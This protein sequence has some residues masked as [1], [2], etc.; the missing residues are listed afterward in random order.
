MDALLEK[1][2]AID[3]KVWI[4]VGIGVSVVVILII[5]LVIGIKGNNNP[6]DMENETGSE[7][8]KGTEVYAGTEDV[9]GTEIFGTEMETEI[10]T[11]IETEMNQTDSKDSNSQPVV[12]TPSTEEGQ[13]ST[14]TKEDGEEI[15]GSG[16]LDEPYMEILD[17][18]TMALVTVE[19]P[20]GET[21]YYSIQRVGG[22]Y[23]SIEDKDAYVVESNGTERVAKNG[24]VYFKL[25]DAMSSDFVTI[26][27]G[28][29]GSVAKKF[30][31]QFSMER[32]TW[33]N[34]QKINNLN[35]RTT[36][37]TAGNEVGYYYIYSASQT[38]KIR[39]YKSGAN[40]EVS[41]TNNRTYANRTFEA[42]VMVDE[43]G[44][45]YIE[46]E[47]N[48]GDVLRIL[49]CALPNSQ[50]KYPATTVVWEGKYQ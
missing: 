31:L 12:T 33:N 13:L 41:V 50:G 2:K 25:E 32:G 42:D 16:T 21:R 36:E 10:G 19:I 9:Y 38:G 24:E 43:S 35:S 3:K 37:L 46:I 47:V 26:Q 1:I 27:I 48:A 40:S 34:P 28:N 39:F 15:L 45:E 29:S 8:V 6:N 22:L 44:N 23:L 18:D 17:A 30:T 49:V 7:L 4:G 20:V 11:E 14:T 5:M